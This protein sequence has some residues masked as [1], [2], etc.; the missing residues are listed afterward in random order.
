VARKTLVQE[1]RQTIKEVNEPA[2]RQTFERRRSR[3]QAR[4]AA[5]SELDRSLRSA[6]REQAAPEWLLAL[7]EET[8]S[9]LGV[10]RPLTDFPSS[11]MATLRVLAEQCSKPVEREVII[12]EGRIQTDPYNFRWIVHRLDEDLQEW[13][14]EI[15]KARGYAKPDCVKRGFIK[16]LR[17][18]RYE[19][20]GKG[21][22]YQLDLD[23]C[24]VRVRGP[25]PAWMR[26]LSDA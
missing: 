25:R 12:R 10:S 22:P 8:I 14:R 24:R 11:G 6:L 1:I 5:L 4:Y 20:R 2:K 19:K 9:L 15:C 23:P 7:T 26:P 17:A 3:A 13:G 21:G 18:P 16:G